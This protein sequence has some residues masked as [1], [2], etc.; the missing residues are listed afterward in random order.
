MSDLLRASFIRSPAVFANSK[1]VR[2]PTLK[3]RNSPG[4]EPC[5]SPSIGHSK[6]QR[7]SIAEATHECIAASQ[8]RTFLSPQFRNCLRCSQGNRDEEAACRRNDRRVIFFVPS[9]S[10]GACWEC[11]FGRGIGR[12]RSRTCG[13]GGGCA[14]WIYGRARDRA[15]LGS[16]AFGV[17]IPRPARKTSQAWSP[18]AWK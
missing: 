16:W 4:R 5:E 9:K 17:A 15:F 10:P 3:W 12:G 2:N 6:S 7:L 18:R 14:H 1:C 13:R 8:A 11:G